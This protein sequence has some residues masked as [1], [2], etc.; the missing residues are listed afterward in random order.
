MT[1]IKAHFIGMQEWTGHA[2][3]ELWNLEEDVIPQHPIGSTVCR[4]TLESL[5]FTPEMGDPMQKAY[6]ERERMLSMGDSIGGC[7]NTTK[8]GLLN[9]TGPDAGW[10]L[11][12]H[13]DLPLEYCTSFTERL[14]YIDSIKPPQEHAL[15]RAALTYLPNEAFPEHVVTAGQAVVTAWQ[16]VDT[17]GQAVDT[18]WQ[19]YV[20][21]GQAYDTARQA[22]DTA[23]QAY[24]WH[25]LVL[26]YAPEIPHSDGVLD[27]LTYNKEAS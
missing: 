12:V 19:A 6:A 1:P 10:A 23:R 26:S 9:Y 20:T 4:Q 3:L 8:P 27:F 15:R 17:A 7:M 24:D 18:A 14:H 16:A 22:Y 2:P 11:W 5:G 21:A 13:H 25:T